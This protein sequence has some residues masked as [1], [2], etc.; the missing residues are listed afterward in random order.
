MQTE[1][2]PLDYADFEGEIPPGN[3]GAGHVIVWDRGTYRPL[4]QQAKDFDTASQIWLV[5]FEQGGAE[6]L[7]GKQFDAILV[8]NYLHRPLM[9][10]I[11]QAVKPG[12]LI[13]YET[14]TVDQPRFGK[15]TNPDY[16]L[17]QGE[18]SACFS[19]W[20]ILVYRE[21]ERGDP[22]CAKASLIAQKPKVH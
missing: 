12:G 11:K 8:F 13:L 10:S 1:D 3:Y 2:H 6:P 5:D 22:I 4:E 21:G 20:K 7:S 14:F 17:Q 9:K 16:L 18:L 15:P 19:D